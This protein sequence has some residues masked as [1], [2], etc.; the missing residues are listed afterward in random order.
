[1]RVWAQPASQ[2][3]W[4]CGQRCTGKRWV[5]GVFWRFIWSASGY[6]SLSPRTWKLTRFRASGLHLFHK[7]IICRRVRASGKISAVCPVH[8]HGA[9]LS[10]QRNSKKG[11]KDPQGG[12]IQGTKGK[13][14][15]NPAP[16]ISTPQIWVKIGHGGVPAIGICVRTEGR[17]RAAV[18]G[19]SALPRPPAPS[20]P[21]SVKSTRSRCHWSPWLELQQSCQCI[22]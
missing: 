3:L 4:G 18:T 8:A 10:K 7:D 6:F 19:G 15:G 1:M 13:T 16:Q 11:R 22:F 9:A 20:F 2:L 12:E 5:V 14:E 21:S 17:Q